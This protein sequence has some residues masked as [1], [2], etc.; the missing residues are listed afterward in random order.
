[1]DVIRRF[2]GLHG[3]NDHSTPIPRTV[4]LRLLESFENLVGEVVKIIDHLRRHSE[5]ALQISDV[6]TPELPFDLRPLAGKPWH[7]TRRIVIIEDRHIASPN[8]EQMQ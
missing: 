1:A 4:A 2:T 6:A 7:M 8:R 3:S 5:I